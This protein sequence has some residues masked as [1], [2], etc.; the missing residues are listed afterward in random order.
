MQEAQRK[1]VLDVWLIEMQEK[2]Y[3]DIENIKQMTIE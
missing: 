1:N 3:I 2:W